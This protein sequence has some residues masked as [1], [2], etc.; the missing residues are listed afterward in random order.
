M[1]PEITSSLMYD[2]IST[3]FAVYH[4]E[5]T[6]IENPT[7]A[8]GK[9]EYVSKRTTNNYWRT[10]FLAARRHAKHS[11]SSRDQSDAKKKKNSPTG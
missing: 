4:G 1:Q 11:G 8:I 5:I 6:S 10:D 7:E 3:A 2:N 9:C